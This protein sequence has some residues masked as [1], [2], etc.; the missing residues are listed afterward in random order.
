MDVFHLQMWGQPGTSD[1]PITPALTLTAP[2][3]QPSPQPRLPSW[4]ISAV[5]HPS[6][7]WL[8]GAAPVCR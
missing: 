4:E 5:S 2:S 3:L 8:P 1:R 6:T 7:A